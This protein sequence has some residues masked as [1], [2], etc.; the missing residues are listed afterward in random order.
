MVY[1]NIKDDLHWQLAAFLSK[2]HSAVFLAPPDLKEWTQTQRA[3]GSVRL[4]ASGLGLFCDRLKES[5]AKRGTWLPDVDEN[6]TTKTC[7]ACGA[8]NWNVGSSETFCCPYCHKTM[9]RDLNAAKNMLLKHIDYRQIW[10]AET[11]RL[12][13]RL[14][15][16]GTESETDR[17]QERVLDSG[18][19][20][21]GSDA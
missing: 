17:H 3:N 16:L 15:C 13:G 19:Q 20:A 4:A 11:A 1:K 5:C 8:I 6:Y 14:R 9:D 21:P 12:F 10:P 2:R 7:S 18:V